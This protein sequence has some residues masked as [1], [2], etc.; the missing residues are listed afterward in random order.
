[1]Q[2]WGP[3]YPSKRSKASLRLIWDGVPNSTQ[4]L[5]ATQCT[6]TKYSAHFG[7]Y[8]RPQ[9]TIFLSNF[10]ENL[11]IILIPSLFHYLKNLLNLLIWLVWLGC[12]T[13]QSVWLANWPTG[14]SK[15]EGRSDLPP[16]SQ[17]LHK[18][19]WS[20]QPPI[21]CTNTLIHLNI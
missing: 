13:S 16:L 18:P 6:H 9:D 20:Q 11:F 17:T 1:M 7:A 14:L 4:L 21:L 3:S 15:Q 12:Q 8:L 10:F 19:E 5:K 2:T